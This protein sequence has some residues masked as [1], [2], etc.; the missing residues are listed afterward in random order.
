MSKNSML[1]INHKEMTYFEIT[2]ELRKNHKGQEVFSMTGQEGYIVTEEQAKAEAK[3]R[4]C[5]LFEEMPTERL[6][7]M[8]QLEKYL[9]VED[10]AEHALN[11]DGV[12]HGL[13]VYQE[14]RLT[15]ID[16]EDGFRLLTDEEKNNEIFLEENDFDTKEEDFVFIGSCWGQCREAAKN[17]FPELMH[18]WEYHLNGWKTGPDGTQIYEPLPEVIRAEILKFIEQDN[19]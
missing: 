11:V 12:L 5:S 8:D 14:D 6:E 18:L 15:C 2:V 3:E 1:R 4:M 17:Y 19:D 9:S 10:A 16:N 7:L 13:D